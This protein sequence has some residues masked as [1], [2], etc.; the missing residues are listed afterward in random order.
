ML[1]AGT[2]FQPELRLAVG[3]FDIAMRLKVAH[4]HILALEKIR[5][6]A[7]D[8]DEAVVLIHPLVDIRGQ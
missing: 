5:D 6:R 4:L 8:A 1:D 2:L 7:I 3:T